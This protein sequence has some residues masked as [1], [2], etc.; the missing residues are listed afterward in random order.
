[1][2]AEFMRD[3]NGTV[4]QY[5]NL[6]LQIWFFYANQIEIRPIRGKEGQIEIKRV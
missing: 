1:M 4:R 3:E 2:R 6:L 5:S